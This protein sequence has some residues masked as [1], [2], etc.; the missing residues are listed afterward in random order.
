MW[1]LIIGLICRVAAVSLIFVI[2]ARA[3]DPKVDLISLH[4][5][6][7]T[8]TVPKKD[9]KELRFDIVLD[10]H[11]RDLLLE[12]CMPRPQNGKLFTL[13]G[14]PDRDKIVETVGTCWRWYDH[15]YNGANYPPAVLQLPDFNISHEKVLWG[16]FTLKNHHGK[17]A[18]GYWVNFRKRQDSGWWWYDSG[19]Q[20]NGQKA[21]VKVR[22]RF[23]HHGTDDLGEIYINNEL[24]FK[25]KPG[26]DSYEGEFL[27]RFQRSR[28]WSEIDEPSFQL[29]STRL[30]VLIG[31]EKFDEL[32]STIRTHSGNLHFCVICYPGPS[33]Q[34]S[35]VKAIERIH[36]ESTI[37]ES[38]VKVEAGVKNNVTSLVFPSA[39]LANNDLQAKLN[40]EW[41]NKKEQSKESRFRVEY[42]V[43]E[44]AINVDSSG[45]LYLCVLYQAI[46]A[47]KLSTPD[48]I[49]KIILDDVL[50]EAR[51]MMKVKN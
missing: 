25:C 47:L 48:D 36:K 11:G 51:M 13:L 18:N 9:S 4:G 42:G 26:A 21:M 33:S 27:R 41:G 30:K 24:A 32:L 8:A 5:L 19:R 1:K 39:F 29:A 2:A 46:G 14:D 44:K 37:E 15:L 50:A 22:L 43:L 38:N 10:P 35:Y 20:F 12:K 34:N 17:C 6:K 23:D 28:L 31:K 45:Y 16:A 7:V 49:K 40:V 3:D